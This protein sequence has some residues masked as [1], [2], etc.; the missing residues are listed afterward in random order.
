MEALSQADWTRAARAGGAEPGAAHRGTFLS[1]GP[2]SR[3]PPRWATRDHGGC[4]GP[5]DRTA[6]R[7][8]HNQSSM[9]R[10][11]R[12][13][14]APQAT[15]PPNPHAISRTTVPWRGSQANPRPE[16][17]ACV[18]QGLCRCDCMEDQETGSC[19]RASAVTQALKRERKEAEVLP[20][21]PRGKAA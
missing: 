3:A 14:H 5:T 11:Q 4:A 9:H 17:A 1:R 16:H 18:L 21:G 10:S 20:A 8:R 12:H 6:Q 7:G 19:W 15:P 2:A 13:C